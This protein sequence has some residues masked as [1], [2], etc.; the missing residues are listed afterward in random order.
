M[1]S[2]T[3]NLCTSRVHTHSSEHTPGAVAAIYAAA[4]GEQL[5]VAQGHLSHGIDVVLRVERALYIYSPHLQVLPDLILELTTFGLRV[6]HS[7]H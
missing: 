5:G 4:P 1:V 7:N 3:P 6:H 2:H